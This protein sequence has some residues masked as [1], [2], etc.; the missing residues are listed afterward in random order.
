MEM[1]GN[2]GYTHGA[3]GNQGFNTAW[4]T[5]SPQW[6]TYTTKPSWAITKSP[7]TKPTTTS[8]VGTTSAEEQ[9]ISR[10]V[11]IQKCKEH[12][13][14]FAWTCTDMKLQPSS[15]YCGKNGMTLNGKGECVS[16][17]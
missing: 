7:W 4:T 17:C 3:P 8:T 13:G 10:D 2:Q 11:A 16:A 6:P 1:S 9:C 12:R 15:V 14:G 5:T